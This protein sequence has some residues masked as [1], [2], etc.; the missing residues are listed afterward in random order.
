MSSAPGRKAGAATPT[1]VQ[2]ARMAPLPPVFPCA[3]ALAYGEDRFG[4]WQAFEVGGARQV[5]RWIPPGS[6]TMGSPTAEAGRDTDES[7]HEVQLTQGF[8]LADTACTQVLWHRVMGV[9]PSHFGDGPETLYNPVEQVSWND[10]V[11]EFIPRLN[12]RV[13]GLSAVLP[14]EAQWEY[15]CRGD[16]SQYA[17]FWFGNQI[18]S[19]Q[20]NFN[21]TGPMPG[22]AESEFRQRTVP[23]KALPC[24]GW[25][26]HQMH[27][28]VFEWCA[29]WY[30]PY[31]AGRVQDPIGPAKSPTESAGRVQRGGSWIVDA[32]VCRSAQRIAGGPSSRD[33]NRGFRLARAAS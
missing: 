17:P 22:G 18:D 8:W 3:W 7:A 16:A 32:R 9:I 19:G 29:D 21:G 14:T 5:M 13:P 4:L 31:P 24:N 1:V 23:V 6:F 11:N 25:G 12:S 27:G 20:V 33:G 28:N 15:A 26:L 30:A 2:R 10:V